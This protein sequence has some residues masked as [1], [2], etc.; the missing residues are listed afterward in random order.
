MLANQK[1]AVKQVEP[2]SEI[3]IYPTRVWPVQSHTD[4]PVPLHY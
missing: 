1:V 3:Y 4:T 2:F